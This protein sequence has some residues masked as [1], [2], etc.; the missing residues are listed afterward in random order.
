M[1]KDQSI[2]TWLKGI[3]CEI[4][5]WKNLFKQKAK[6]DYVLHRSGLNHDICLHNFEAKPFLLSLQEKNAGK[7]P[8][9]ID[10]GCGLSYYTGN[11]LNGEP[12]NIRFVDPLAAFYNKILEQAHIQAPRIE[13]GMMEYISSFYQKDEAS[14][15]IIQNAL[16]HSMNPMKGI[17]ESLRTL[18]VGGVLYLKHYPNEAE[19]EAYR[20]F[21]QFNVSKEGSDLVIWNKEERLNVNALLKSFAHVEVS[22]YSPPEEVVAV[23]TKTDE[24][25]VTLTDDRQ[26]RRDLCRQLLVQA[27]LTNRLSFVLK[28]HSTKGFY[29]IM[30]PIAALFSNKSLNKIR[31]AYRSLTAS[32]K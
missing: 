26:D 1:N 13:F 6:K 23:I 30:R 14:L 22:T 2:E 24:V 5:F 31:A 16:D 20:G 28:Y 11:L 19:K 10:L 29:T 17:I 15:I 3:P 21:H 27:Q 9:V 32:K 18:H 8:L 12:L 7:K 25:P 4:T